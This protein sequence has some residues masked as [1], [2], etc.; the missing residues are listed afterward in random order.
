[1]LTNDDAVGIEKVDSAA[2]LAVLNGVEHALDFRN[3][4]VH[5]VDEAGRPIGNVE[6]N[7]MTGVDIES[8]KGV[9]ATRPATDQRGRRHVGDFCVGITLDHGLSESVWHDHLGVGHRTERNV[10]AHQKQEDLRD[11]LFIS[12]IS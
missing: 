4:V 3:L 6:V 5:Q 9:K 11:Y 2:N 7:R 8:T 10:P 12:A 1:T